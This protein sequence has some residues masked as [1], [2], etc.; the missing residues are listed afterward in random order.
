MVTIEAE[1]YDAAIKQ[2]KQAKRQQAKQAKID[3]AQMEQSYTEAHANLGRICSRL[4]DPTVRCNIWEH[5]PTM[6]VI[7]E[8]TIAC[9]ISA[10]QG[11]ATREFY[12]YEPIRVF[13]NGAGF[14]IGIEIRDTDTDKLEVYAVGVC[15]DKCALVPVPGIV[16]E[17]LVKHLESKK[18]S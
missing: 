4:L 13:L 15:A 16:I 18:Q 5:A 7:R 6:K 3:K 9:S 17:A 1:N 8:N 12:K 14:T 11:T 2:A 10:E